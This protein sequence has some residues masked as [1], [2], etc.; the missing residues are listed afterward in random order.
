[1]PDL[2]LSTK[3]FITVSMMCELCG[4]SRSR[5]YDLTASGVFPK[6]ILH[7][8][9]KRPMYDRVLQEKCLEIVQTGIGANGAPV[10]FNRKARK[11]GPAKQQRKIAPA[12]RSDQG[13]IADALRSLGLVVSAQAVSEAVSVLY[14]GGLHGHEQGDVVRKVFLHLKAPKK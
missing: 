8:S 11:I 9:S 4:I 12:Q 1:M 6:P 13:E 7:P 5:W 3:A 10:L 14:P 2:M